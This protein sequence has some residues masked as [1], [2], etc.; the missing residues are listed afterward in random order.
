MPAGGHRAY[1][2]LP[3]KRTKDE[4]EAALLV[5]GVDDILEGVGLHTIC[6]R[7]NNL[8]IPSATGKV[9]QKAVLRNSPRMVGWRVYGPPSIPIEERY[10]RDPEGRPV[11]GRQDLILELDTWMEVVAKLRDPSHTSKHVHTGGRK[12]LL[13][14]II[15]CGYCGRHLMGAY[16]RD[17]LAGAY[18]F[19]RVREQEQVILTLKAEQTEWLRAHCGPGMTNVAASWPSLEVEQRREIIGTVIEAVVL[20]AADGP[21]NR[22]GPGRVEVV[23]RA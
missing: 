19:P 2:W 5:A 21:K 6:R 13:S 14:G 10:A 4:A 11:K 20:K 23:W 8:G 3:D 18:V 7:W 15:C 1:G 9:W 12:Y 16:D 17:E 22:F